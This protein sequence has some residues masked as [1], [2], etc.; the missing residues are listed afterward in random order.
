[1]TPISPKKRKTHDNSNKDSKY[2]NIEGY[3]NLSSVSLKAV[4]AQLS[5]KARNRKGVLYG[6][7]RTDR[8]YSPIKTVIYIFRQKYQL[9]K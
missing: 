3:V 8:G 4:I 7:S 2:E 5:L 1:M 6:Y 9:T